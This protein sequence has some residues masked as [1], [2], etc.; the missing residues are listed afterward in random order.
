[1]ND[2]YKTLHCYTGSY[3]HHRLF[4]NSQV[5]DSFRKLSRILVEETV[6]YFGQY[7]YQPL[8]SCHEFFKCR[9]HLLTHIHCT[10][11]L[12]GPAKY[13]ISAT[14]AIGRVLSVDESA[15]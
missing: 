11:T 6:A 8:V 13:P 12:L 4:H 3:A 15:S 14:T 10:S 5:Q 7:H 9:Y 2:W 1:M